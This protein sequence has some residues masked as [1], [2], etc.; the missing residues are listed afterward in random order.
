MKH[1]P[2]QPTLPQRERRELRAVGCGVT[3]FNPRSHKGSD[4]YSQQ[5]QSRFLNFNPRSHKG[6]D[7]A[8]AVHSNS[9]LEFQPTLPQRER[10]FLC[11]TNRT[12]GKNFNPRSHKGS[13][14][15]TI[16]H[17]CHGRISTHAPT[18]G[19]TLFAINH[20]F[21][22]YISTHAPTKGATTGSNFPVSLL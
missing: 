12:G 5:S 20:D 8:W 21:F 6:S 7:Q 22:A 15:V 4:R 14:I 11:T 10:L 16:A 1:N 3:D 9:L 19:A 2:F 13:D 17:P 18:K